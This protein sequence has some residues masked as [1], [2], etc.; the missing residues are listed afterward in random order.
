MARLFLYKILDNSTKLNYA[1][2]VV[3]LNEW[4]I[5]TDSGVNGTERREFSHPDEIKEMHI[6]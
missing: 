5:S 2:L 1:T 4:K 3:E 6:T